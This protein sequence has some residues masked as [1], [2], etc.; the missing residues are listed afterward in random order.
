MKKTY[1]IIEVNLSANE[2]KTVSVPLRNDY[3]YATGIFFHMRSGSAIGTS[4][5][6][7]IANND[8]LPKGSDLTLFAFSPAYSRSETLWD[9]SKDNIKA[10]SNQLTVEFDNT[11]GEAKTIAI[12]VLLKND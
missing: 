4:I 9:F 11:N 1:Q 2:E 3:E 10:L 5:Q 6:V 7:R 8:I 12:Y